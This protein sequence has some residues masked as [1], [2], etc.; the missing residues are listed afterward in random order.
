[1]NR[2]IKDIIIRPM[3]TVNDDVAPPDTEATVRG[4]LETVP[5]ATLTEEGEPEFEGEPDSEVVPDPVAVRG[6]EVAVDLSDDKG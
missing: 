5:E 4:E 3:E 6:V 2:E 1:M